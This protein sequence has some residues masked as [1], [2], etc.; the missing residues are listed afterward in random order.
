MN[1]YTDG[2]EKNK[3]AGT[4]TVIG[5]SARMSVE[6]TP[7]IEAEL[8]N[9]NGPEGLEG[10]SAAIFDEVFV[11]VNKCGCTNRTV[12][13]IIGV[14][15]FLVILLVIIGIAA[16]VFGY[17]FIFAFLCLIAMIISCFVRFCAFCQH[18]KG[19]DE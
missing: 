5:G 10:I 12:N 1:K 15:L 18:P 11:E 17:I 3:T 7:L 9:P 4:T 6:G 2:P 13:I 19:A 8:A 16:Q 14:F